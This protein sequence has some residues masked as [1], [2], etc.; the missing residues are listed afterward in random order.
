MPKDLL[1]RLILISA[2]VLNL[3]S[4]LFL[5]FH[6]PLLKNRA[7]NSSVI[8]HYNIYL[9]VDFLGEWYKIFIIPTL[10]LAILVINFVLSYFLYHKER[11][12]SYFLTG[13]SGLVQI[14][15]LLA[16]IMIIEANKI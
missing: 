9:G 6:L 2:F 12:L 1:S 13:I 5:Y 8:L 16:A 3:I 15:L 11:F 4:W 7:D 10:G 14:I